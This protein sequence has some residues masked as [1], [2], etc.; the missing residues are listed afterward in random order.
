MQTIS[1]HARWHAVA[2][3]HPFLAWVADRAAAA[4][5][6]AARHLAPVVDVGRLADGRLAADVLRPVGSA[7]S[8]ALD[9]LG[10]PTTGVAVTL[11]V[12][13]LELALA[14]RSGALQIGSAGLDDVLVDDAGAIVLCDRP[15]ASDGVR[16]SDQSGAR[17]LVLAARLVW[18]RTDARAADR[19]A[20]DAVLAEALDGD[21]A[22]V[23]TALSVVR[24][25]AAPRPIRW[26]RPSDDLFVGLPD[27]PAAVAGSSGS[28]GTAL[29]GVV[30]QGIPLGGGRRLPLRRA[31]VGIVVAA[32]VTAATVFTIG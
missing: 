11:T 20:V 31:L 3:E 9:T 21:T 22:T 28:L 2:D 14:E 26:E 25:A 8:A 30:E 27:G 18:E 15:P 12:P 32:G 13:M 17:V 1:D 6:P 5:D 16:R 24:G 23:R 4:T 29:R 19:P 7:L 10:T